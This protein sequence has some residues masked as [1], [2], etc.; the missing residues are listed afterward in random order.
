MQFVE[1]ESGRNLSKYQCW[2]EVRGRSGREPFY[3]SW[4]MVPKE[5]YSE[6]L[7]IGYLLFGKD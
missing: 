6:R 2:G 5:Y 7:F 4:G 3:P 1:I